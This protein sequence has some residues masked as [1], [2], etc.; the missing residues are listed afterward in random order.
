[1]VF[2]SKQSKCVQKG[3]NK[4]IEGLGQFL[5]MRVGIRGDIGNVGIAVTIDVIVIENVSCLT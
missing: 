4:E 5:I 2:D 3:E 1:M